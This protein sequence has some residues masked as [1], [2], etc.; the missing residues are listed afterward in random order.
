M[1]AVPAINTSFHDARRALGALRAGVVVPD[2]QAL[3]AL[4]G[5]VDVPR[6]AAAQPVEG[7]TIRARRVPG[8][9]EVGFAAFLDGTQASRVLAYV[10]GVAVIHGTIAA[11]IRERRNRRMTTWRHETAH[12]VYA[13]RR[14]LPEGQWELLEQLGLPL[15]DTS[16]EAVPAGASSSHPFTMR[17]SAIHRVGRDRERLEQELAQRWCQREG[18][19]MLFIDGGIGGNDRVATASCTAGV[20][21]SHRTL[22]VDG[23]DL[24]RVLALESGE[25][26]TVFR[27]ASTKRAP[28]ASWY[29]RLRAA[30]GTDPMFGLVRVEMADLPVA[31]PARFTARADELS[32]WILAEV[33]P[34]ALPDGRW[35]RMVYGIRDCEEFLRAIT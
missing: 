3:E 19:G 35:D 18:A 7:G 25:R 5:A 32:R 16:D 12:R 8:P 24:K 22:Y 29:L 28:V 14:A 30:A 9:P 1:T 4:S 13:P 21:K 11:V 15:V 34:L 23:D 20:V 26:S 31:E 33:A 17:D 27:I 10:E 6:V 2:G